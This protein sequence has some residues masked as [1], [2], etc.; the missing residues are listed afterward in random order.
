[1]KKIFLLVLISLISPVYAQSSFD[2]W[3]SDVTANNGHVTYSAN[4]Y[5]PT[6]NDTLYIK[7]RR[8]YICAQQKE[9]I[10]WGEITSMNTG[11]KYDYS[12]LMDQSKLR[13]YV[14][15]TNVDYDRIRQIIQYC[16]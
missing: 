14:P 15:I 3:V 10:L 1:M 13:K 11:R 9:A 8:D 6:Q 5:M 16:Q 2:T 12:I 7:N 4:V